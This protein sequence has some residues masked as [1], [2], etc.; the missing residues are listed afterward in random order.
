MEATTADVPSK[1]RKRRKL[2]TLL[3]VL[4]VLL[5]LLVVTVSLAPTLLSTDTGK[6]FI[7][8]IAND[9]LPGSLKIGSLSLSW[10][11]GQQIENVQLKDADGNPMLKLQE[12]STEL[13]LWKA[14]GGDYNLGKTRLRN[15]DVIIA[16]KEPPASGPDARP[17]E[18]APAETP[19]S[20]PLAWENLLPKS[21]IVD[22]EL[23]EASITI[24]TPGKQPVVIDN[25]E[26][27]L[28]HVAPED[29]LRFRLSGRSRQ[30]GLAGSFT[31]KGELR[32]MFGDR[33]QPNAQ[34]QIAIKDLPTDGV[35]GLLDL[36]GLLSAGLG[37]TINVQVDTTATTKSQDLSLQI[38][39][40]NLTARFTG[41]AQDGNFAL[42]EAGTL[43][44]TLTP[45]LVQKLATA[46]A[47]GF[48]AS[49]V[50]SG[51]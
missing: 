20:E 24:T 3:R 1:P 12:F 35:D 8:G 7:E 25:L 28:T 2:F 45:E 31:G 49:S 11:G 34:V 47:K 51:G 32:G 10:F 6:G 50:S 5:V 4:L 18:A 13:T 9:N 21:L 44:A 27:S 48:S 46:K 38:H 30:G 14:L 39:C 42:T 43:T 33:D 36:G 19:P 26:F 16:V 15:L 22:A 23:T 29:P 40:A 41:Q 37:P 17:S